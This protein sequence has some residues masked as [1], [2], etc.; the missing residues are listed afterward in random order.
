VSN[1]KGPAVLGKR[2]WRDLA[3]SSQKF[4][5]EFAVSDGNDS[6]MRDEPWKYDKPPRRL[7]RRDCEKVVWE[8]MLKGGP[9]GKTEENLN[10][11]ESS[12]LEIE[13]VSSWATEV[14]LM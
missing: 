4:G 11:N 13:V 12:V 7:D 3:A 6:E 10:L 5:P 2:C 1:S 14:S 9:E 8:L